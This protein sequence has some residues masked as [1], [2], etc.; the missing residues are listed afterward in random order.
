MIQKISQL[1]KTGHNKRDKKLN[2][3]KKL[4]PRRIGHGRN[5]DGN[6]SKKE[7]EKKN[8]KNSG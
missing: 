5:E 7:S 8:D 6:N 1:N 2:S 4:K 3:R